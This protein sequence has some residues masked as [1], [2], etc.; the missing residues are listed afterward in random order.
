M[1]HFTRPVVKLLKDGPGFDGLFWVGKLLQVE[2]SAW[3]DERILSCSLEQ[4]TL[5]DTDWLTQR[6]PANA[7]RIHCLQLV[8]CCMDRQQ[9]AYV[10]EQPEPAVW[11][12]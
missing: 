6:F 5:C 10:L 8:A 11:F 4:G 12:K 3:M 2:R 7:V 1:S 9:K